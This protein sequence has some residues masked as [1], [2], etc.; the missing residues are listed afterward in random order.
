[1]GK[2]E[3]VNHV[4]SATLSIINAEQRAVVD[5]ITGLADVL[6]S[7]VTMSPDGT[8][9]WAV[10]KMIDKAT[11]IDLETRKIVALLDTRL[12]SN[13]PKFADFERATYGLITVAGTN[14]AKVYTQNKASEAPSFVQSITAGGIE[15]HG[16]TASRDGR[17][18]YWVNEHS[19]TLDVADLSS[20][21]V[22]A[23]LPIGQESQALVYVPNAVPSSTGTENLGV[24]GLN[25]RV[26][27]RLIGV[28]GSESGSASSLREY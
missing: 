7:D 28:T 12:E 15:P 17:W 18:L 16:I 25:K 13:H 22:T 1:M 14:E 23:T 9:L 21:E 4:S 6:S 24:L 8:P 5:V 19:N 20:L 27:N 26:E 10:H 3:H 2:L 11:V